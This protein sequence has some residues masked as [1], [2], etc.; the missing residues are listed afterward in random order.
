MKATKETS[1]NSIVR[2]AFAESKKRYL[3]DSLPL[4]FFAL[5]AIAFLM[6]GFFF[7][8]TLFISIPFFIIPAFFGISAVNSIA[9]NI[10]TREGLGFFIMF[11]A[12]FS[13]TFRGGYKV[14][15]GFLKGLIVFVACSSILSIILT[16]TL[17]LNDPE[18]IQL[19]NSMQ[20]TDDID[21]LLDAFNVFTQ[22]NTTFLKI[23]YIDSI[24]SFLFG[25]YA[26]LH[27][28]SANAIKYNYNFC[29]SMPLPM[30]DLNLI[31]KLVVKENKKQYWK[32]YFSCFWFLGIIY[33]IGYA[34]GTLVSYFFIPGIDMLQAIVL[35][36][37]CSL[38]LLILFIPYYLCAS[39]LLFN[40]YRSKYVDT[41]I[42]M[43]KKSLEELKKTN[44]ITEEK[45]KEVMQIIESQKDN[46]KDNEENK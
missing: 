27:H 3:I 4:M 15:F 46:N 7:P 44:K 2:M 42:E 10:N 31:H 16:N 12:Y 14:L 34:A 37:F 35:G 20:S 17:L 33:I 43:S 25:S 5:I 18:Y 39:Q 8:P 45:E 26:F 28:F 11:K 22:T 13:Q 23:V 19:I 29:A 41:L 38:I 24:V 6:L 32:D 9:Y 30:H 1:K 21:A 36:L 40:K